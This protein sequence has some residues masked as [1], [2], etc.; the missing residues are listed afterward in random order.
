MSVISK[1]DYNTHF[2]NTKLTSTKISLKTFSDE[3]VI[4]LGVFEVKSNTKAK[5]LC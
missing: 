5:M 4:P 2:G 3:K 1:Q